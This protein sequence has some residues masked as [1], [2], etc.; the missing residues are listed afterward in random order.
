MT[1]RT[2]KAIK[3]T[4]TSFVQFGVL[5]ILQAVL[6]PVVLKTAG[7]DVLGAYVILMQIIGYG[8]LLDFGLGVAIS[9]YLS[10]SFGDNNKDA[11][12]TKIFNIGRFFTLSVNFLISIFM[13]ALAFKLDAFLTGNDAVIADARSGLYLLS[14]WTIIKT[15]LVLYSHGLMASQNIASANVIGLIG[16]VIRLVLSLYLVFAGFGLIGLVIAN[17]VSELI[18]LL[19]QKIHFNRLYPKLDMRWYRPDGPLLSELF[20]FGLKYWSVNIVI[21]LSVGS[22]SIIVGHLYGAAAAAIFYTTKMP[23][24]LIIQVIFKISDSSG[25]AT[26]EL[27]ALGNFEALKS[28]YLKLLRYS[29]LLAVPLA[30]GIVGFNKG[31]ISAW[32]GSS[33][34]AGDA[35]TIG[36]ACYAITQVVNHI[37]AMI[38]VAA[39]NMRHWM[40]ISILTGLLTIVLAYALGKTFGLQWVMV[41]IAAMDIPFLIFLTCRSFSVLG[42]KYCQALREAILPTILASLPLFGWI[43][44]VMA[45]DQVTSLISLIACVTVFALLWTLGLYVF[46]INKLERKSIKNRLGWI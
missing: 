12:F 39:G 26:N 43:G 5:V 38:T 30:I 7:Q 40:T 6:T 8:L 23:P 34:Y 13:I 20:V 14:A 36:L 45:M 11:K 4:I 22:D 18:G 28:A 1:T 29:L 21:V 41:A 9:R 3:G 42:L 15:P 17:I 37:N 24:F 27:F 32:V 19:I 35:M 2:N 10:Q 16:I 33:Q 44:F 46:G 31:I 25:P